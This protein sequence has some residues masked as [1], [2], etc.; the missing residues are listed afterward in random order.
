[1]YLVS[2]FILVVALVEVIFFFYLRMRHRELL[3]QKVVLDELHDH[4]LRKT[5]EAEAMFQE[6][7]SFYK[8]ASSMAKSLEK[9]IVDFSLN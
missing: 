3:S 2:F 4:Y 5:Q 6:A 1:M 7:T 8:E 9:H